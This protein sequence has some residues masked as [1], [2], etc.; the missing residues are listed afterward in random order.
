MALGAGEVVAAPDW[1]KVPV[2]KINAFYPGVAS[3]EWVTTVADHSGAKGIRKGETCASC[4]EM[5][6][7]DIGAKIASGEKLEPKPVK[8]KAG[9]I[10]VSVQAA[11]DAD[12]LYIRFQ[13]KDTVPS[14]AEK[15]DKKNQVKVALM[16]EDN[17]VELGNIGG[18]WATCHSD[19]RGMPDVNPDA[20]KHPRAKEIDIRKNGPTKYIKESRTSIELK[21]PPRGGWDKLRPEAELA[22]LL[23]EGKFFYMMQYRDSEKP[24]TGYVLGGR[25]LKAA[26]GAAEGRHADGTWT[27]TFTRKLA[28]SGAGD[29][30]IAAGKTYNFG[31][32]IHDDWANERHHHVSFGY[33]IGLDDAKADIQAVKQ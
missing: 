1:N 30:A 18:C 11:H 8:G 16:L 2:K 6:E 19:L 23:K 22:A 10:A 27:V 25:F 5:E 32:A 3:F 13:W 28:A 14:G 7:P 21:T 24:R 31:F 33:T 17:K 4:H 9:S 15:E 29:F 12:N 20:A 26:E